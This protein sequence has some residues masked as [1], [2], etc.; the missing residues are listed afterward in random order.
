[1]VAARELRINHV[2]SRGVPLPEK[3]GVALSALK[4]LKDARCIPPS[5]LSLDVPAIHYDM[6]GIP[7]RVCI[8]QASAR[9]PGACVTVTERD[10]PANYVLIAHVHSDV[11]IC[12]SGGVLNGEGISKE[13][14]WQSHTCVEK[15]LSKDLWQNTVPERRIR[16]HV[17]SDNLR[18]LVQE[19]QVPWSPR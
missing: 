14:L 19:H 17:L 5:D 2:L 9:S 18:R 1:M 13:T 15:D 11:W 6:L 16:I 4:L 10:C 12:S 7:R 3:W 8:P